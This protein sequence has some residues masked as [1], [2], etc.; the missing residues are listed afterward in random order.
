M[1]ETHEDPLSVFR[2]VNTFGTMNLARQAVEAGVKRFI[3]LSSI[4]VNGED[5]SNIPFY[6]DDEPN[7]QNPYAISI[8]EA[9]Q[10]LLAFGQETGLEVVIIRPP[11]VYGPGVKGNFSRLIKLVVKSIPL[12]L[13][14]IKN[15][16]SLVNIQNLCSLIEIC[17]SHPKAEYERLFG[18]LQVD[19]AKNRE[20]LGW[21]PLCSVEEGIR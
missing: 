19:I 14:G 4:K 5:T 13:A 11:L 6:A 9:E 2:D 1:E 21:K 7:P 20:L 17:L 8:F 12:P 18:S 15:S 10:K 3:Y 16:R